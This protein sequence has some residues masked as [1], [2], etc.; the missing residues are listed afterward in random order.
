MTP[1]PPPAH[2]PNLSAQTGTRPA[3]LITRAPAPSGGRARS[4][5]RARPARP[6]GEPFDLWG[7][8]KHSAP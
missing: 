8:D 6:Q 3:D 5:S 2:A 1:R 4:P 7:C